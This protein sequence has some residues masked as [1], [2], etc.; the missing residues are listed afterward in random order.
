ML[1]ERWSLHTMSKFA[2]RINCFFK[3]PLDVNAT[4]HPEWNR[5]YFFY[6]FW[7]F[8]KVAMF[9]TCW[10]YFRHLAGHCSG[11]STSGNLFTGSS[12][13]FI[14]CGIHLILDVY[15]NFFRQKIFAFS[16]F[17]FVY[18]PV[19]RTLEAAGIV[20]DQIPYVTSSMDVCFSKSVMN[21]I[22][23]TTNLRQ[24]SYVLES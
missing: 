17:T 9:V 24:L 16:H 13:D 19:C 21:Y 23:K 4:F 14:Y 18:C 15:R 20:T 5:S 6:L 11:S 8:N 12:P 1:K 3:K 7:V 10:P 22:A 2:R